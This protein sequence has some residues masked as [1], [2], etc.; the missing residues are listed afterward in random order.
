MLSPDHPT[1]SDRTVLHARQVLSGN[2]R[3][4]RAILPFAGPAV[5]V[6]VAYVDPGNFA[7][8]IQT[9]RDASNT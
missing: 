2:R 5:V 9:L 3:G 7:T 8:N 1:F 4:F 6:S